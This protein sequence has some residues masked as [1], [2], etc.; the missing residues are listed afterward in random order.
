MQNTGAISERTREG[1]FLVAVEVMELNYKLRTDPRTRPWR[2][3]FSSYTQWHA[4]SLALV[5][6]KIKH[7]CR[8]SRRAWEAVEKAVVLRWEHPASLLKGKETSAVAIDHEA[9]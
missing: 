3:L 8:N 4:F 1:L 5:W 9:A 2:W 7:F 6:L